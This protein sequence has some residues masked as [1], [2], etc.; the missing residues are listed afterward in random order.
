MAG[1]VVPC[2]QTF[3]TEDDVVRLVRAHIEGLFPRV[4]P[5]CGRR[6]GSLRDYLRMTTHLESP[7]LYDEIDGEIPSDPL[8]P[9]S[10]AN[11]PC[12]TTLTVGSRGMPASQMVEMLKWAKQESARRSIGVRDLLLHLRDRIDELTL[13]GDD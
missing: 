12:G 1:R 4:C 3:M 2:E 13:K 10:F 5:N 11:C 9:I 6:F 7:V 8:G